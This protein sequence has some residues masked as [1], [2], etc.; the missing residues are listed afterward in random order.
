MNMP[1]SLPGPTNPVD[2]LR[3]PDRAAEIPVT[4]DR[5]L[6]A[7]TRKTRANPRFSAAC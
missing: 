3:D 1:V 2:P 6:P 5:P 4:P 7:C